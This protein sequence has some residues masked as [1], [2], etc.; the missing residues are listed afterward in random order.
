MDHMVIHKPDH[1]AYVLKV[2]L[3]EI[4]SIIDD[5]NVDS[6]YTEIR[7]QKT[8]GVRI[9]NPSHRR[10]KVIQKRI[11]QN[12][13]NNLK[14]PDY[15]YGA[16]KGRDNVDN[17]KNHRGK[18]YKFTTDLRSFFPSVTN[19]HVFQRFRRYG[20]SPDVSHILTKLTTYKGRLP[21]GAPTS[22]SV[23]N[24]VFVKTG[25][26]LAAFAKRHQIT[27][28]S[29]VDDLAFSSP[30]DFK[31]K[32]EEL[33]DMITIDGFRISHEKT[34]YSR[35]PL[36]TGLHPMNNHL[37]L[38]DKFVKKLSNINNANPHQQQGMKLYKD[39]VEKAN[40][41]SNITRNKEK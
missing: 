32:V 35:N 40:K 30:V 17:V 2:N 36:I 27:F 8:K 25:D 38:S 39:K 33:I 28:T 10:L 11:Q 15:S 19:T 13:L 16:V 12:I 37:R 22:S 24:L 1:L 5:R 20:F 23:A 3:K 31:D 7:K 6:F 34:N 21:Q 4:I 18:K 29:F 41:K 9:I 14:L 26:N